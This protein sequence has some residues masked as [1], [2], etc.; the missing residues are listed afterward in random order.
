[1]EGVRV[2]AFIFNG[3][4]HV[5]ASRAGLVFNAVKWPMVEES[6]HESRIL[7]L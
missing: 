3:L 7:N 1:L 4:S 6:I 2:I 5:N